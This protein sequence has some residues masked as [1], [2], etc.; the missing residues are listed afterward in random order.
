[1]LDK[2][3]DIHI[4]FIYKTK[5]GFEVATEQIAINEVVKEKKYKSE[6]KINFEKENGEIIIKFQSGYAKFS[7]ANAELTS[8]VYGDKQMLSDRHG[9]SAKIFRAL[10]DNDM[11]IGKKWEKKGY[12][13][14]VN[15]LKVTSCEYKKSGVKLKTQG[16]IINKDTAKKLFKL[17]ISYSFIGDGVIKVKAKLK[18]MINTSKAIDLPRFGLNIELD[19]SLSNVKYYG[20]GDLENLPDFKEQSRIGIFESTVEDM[21]VTYIKP[22]DNGN[23]GQTRWVE[24]TN[25]YGEGVMISNCKDYFSFSVHDHKFDTLVKANHI[26]DVTN[27]GV[28]SVMID[29]FMRGTGTNSC[30]QDVLSEYKVL[31]KDELKF[32]FYIVPIIKK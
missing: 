27:D 15:H 1:M 5:R 31:M 28:I 16:Y 24:L 2:N 18:P 29:G 21:N 8:L 6:Q 11:Y 20:L 9:F 25:D 3:N 17:K 4:N 22:Q 10:L 13:L 7:E 32:G 30:G 26:E 14:A 23:H 19:N 12:N